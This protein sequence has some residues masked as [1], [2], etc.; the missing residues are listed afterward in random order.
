VSHEDVLANVLSQ[1]SVPATSNRTR[2]VSACARTIAEWVNYVNGVLVD[3]WKS[4]ELK[5]I[6][7][8]YG[9]TYDA[10]FRIN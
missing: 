10:D 6:V 3:L 4:R 9:L 8:S 5:R 7:A 1:I 2:P